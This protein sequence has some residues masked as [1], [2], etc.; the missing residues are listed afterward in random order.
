M[1]SSCGII[2]TK[3][4]TNEA[5]KNQQ[6][7]PLRHSL[8]VSIPQSTNTNR[9]KNHSDKRPQ[10]SSLH[11]MIQTH[12]IS[13]CTVIVVIV[14]AVCDAGLAGRIHS[15][16]SGNASRT[17]RTQRLQQEQEY[18][19]KRNLPFRLDASHRLMKRTYSWVVHSLQRKCRRRNSSI[20]R[21]QGKWS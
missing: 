10:G 8:Y 17:G 9:N 2:W 6:V 14:V 19:K 15:Y 16:S 20:H 3:E 11:I 21:A 18:K 1:V 7:A 5:T 12:Y 4:R 13:F